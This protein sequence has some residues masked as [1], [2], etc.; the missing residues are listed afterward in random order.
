MKCWIGKLPR[1]TQFKTLDAYTKKYAKYKFKLLTSSDI[2]RLKTE[3]KI[4][5]IL[6]KQNFWLFNRQYYN[7]FYGEIEDVSSWQRDSDRHQCWL[8]LKDISILTSE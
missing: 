8:K 2:D 1:K 7:S 6:K 4:W 5:D 3:T